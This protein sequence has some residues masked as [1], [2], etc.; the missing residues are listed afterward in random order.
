MCT[1]SGF[2][3]FVVLGALCALSAVLVGCVNLDK[4]PTAGAR[5]SIQFID[6]TSY[7]M[8]VH[9]HAGSRE[10]TDRTTA[11]LMG[12]KSRSTLQVA[13]GKPMVM[14][15][16]MDAGYRGQI[17]LGVGGA[18]GADLMASTSKQCTPSLEFTPEEGRSYLFRMRSDGKDCSYEFLAYRSEVAKEATP[19]D[20]TVRQWIRAMGESGPWCKTPS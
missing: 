2:K 19:V 7:K 17:R 4:E 12:P 16:G 9:F 18:I 10:C 20:L 5:A 11:E 14:T 3:K 15:V 6:D 13:A 8:S 1:G